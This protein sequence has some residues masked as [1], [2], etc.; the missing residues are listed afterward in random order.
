MMGSGGLIVMDEDT[1]MVDVARYFLEFLC[2]ESCGKCTPCRE[3]LKHMAEIVVD[4]T[5]GRATMDQLS[6]LEELAEVVRDTSLCGLGQTAPNPVL[7][8]VKYF[9][10]EYREHVE[11]RKC[12]AGVCRALVTYEIDAEACTGCLRCLKACPSKAISGE[13]KMA[14]TIDTSLCEKCG[15]CLEE[16]EF[17]AVV[18]K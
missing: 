17:D 15:I 8:T 1:C 13:K 9:A 16:C 14:H 2:D 12:R 11:S 6:L 7:S 3:G 4:V 10:E 5:E 18:R